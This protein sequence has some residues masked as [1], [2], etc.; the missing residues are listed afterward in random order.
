M[1]FMID[2]ENT[3][4]RG[5]DGVEYLTKEDSVTI[6]YSNSCKKIGQGRLQQ[7]IDSKCEFDICCLQN[8]GKNALDF[9][10][11]SR[12]GEIYGS[13]FSGTTAIV[14]KDNGFK[15]VKDYWKSCSCEQRNIILK[16]VI[17]E[18]ILSANEDS[19]RRLIIKE[20]LKD[21]DISIEFKKYEERIKIR[22]RL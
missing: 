4:D 18:S 9:Y 2:F 15:A 7:I 10:I 13:G 14:S 22:K 21:V 8:T 6:F 1:N 17:Q 19:V 16:P 5:L 12:I 3:R 11:A 20:K